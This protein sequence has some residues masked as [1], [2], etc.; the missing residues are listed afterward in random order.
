MALG[1]ALPVRGEE[2]GTVAAVEGSAEIGRGD[3]W[4]AATPG[5]VVAVG[6]RLSTGQPGRMR[7]VFRDDS[8]L[9]LSENTTLVVD[10]QV[11]DPSGSESIFNLLEGKLRSIVSHYYGTVGSSFEVHSPA[12][13]A[14]VRGTEFVMT[15]D[16]ASGASE[17]VGIR[18][19]VTVHSMVDPTGPGLLVTAN[20]ATAIAPGAQPSPP[21]PVDPEIM[22]QLLHEMEFFGMTGRTSVVGTS[23]V[24]AG[25]SVPQPARAPAASTG[26]ALTLAP[27]GPSAAIDASTALGNSPAAIIN[28]GRGSIIVDPGRP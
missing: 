13:V 19:A 10:E 27:A 17:V 11:F 2:V 6:D 4:S 18:G 12:A 21:R 25:A 16:A 1:A 3:T 15:Y 7:V 23:S 22:R 14:G 9:V 26:R 28:G 20:E 5:T 24:I 8:V